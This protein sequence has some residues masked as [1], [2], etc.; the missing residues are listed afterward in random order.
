MKTRLLLL[1]LVVFLIAIGS[2]SDEAQPQVLKPIASF[3]VEKEFYELD[4]SVRFINTSRNA[5]A[6]HWQFCIHGT[7]TEQNPVY[8]PPVPPD[9][10]GYR[11]FT[12]LTAMGQDASSSEMNKHITASHRLLNK[13]IID[14]ISEQTAELIPFEEG[15]TTELMVLVGPAAEPYEWENEYQTLPAVIFTPCQEFPFEVANFI[16]APICRMGKDAFLINIFARLQGD[17]IPV[18]LHSFEFFPTIQPAEKIIN[19][20]HKFPLE[21]NQMSLTVE[22]EYF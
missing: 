4:E 15:S 7:S 13:I 22:Y 20:L 3:E 6:Y 11:M 17:Q 5:V 10:P 18:L 14:N 21:S 2:C 9:R 8:T 1:V 16:S 12:I 19:K